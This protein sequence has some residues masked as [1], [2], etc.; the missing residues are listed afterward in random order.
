MTPI[1]RVNRDIFHDIARRK[2]ARA[3]AGSV[4]LSHPLFSPAPPLPVPR[5]AAHHS[6][7]PSEVD[8]KFSELLFLELSRHAPTTSR[9]FHNVNA[10][11]IRFADRRPDSAYLRSRASFE[12]IS[13]SFANCCGIPSTSRKFLCTR[14]RAQLIINDC[15]QHEVRKFLMPCRNRAKL[16]HFIAR[17]LFLSNQMR[18]FND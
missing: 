13:H 10:I 9:K 2:G 12:F 16:H 4:T 18:L 7:D 3:R 8:E 6:A 15:T 1:S 14:A 5:S 17:C 11:A